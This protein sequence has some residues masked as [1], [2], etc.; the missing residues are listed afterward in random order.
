MS[1]YCSNCPVLHF[2]N[3]TLAQ[4]PEHFNCHNLCRYDVIFIKKILSDYNNTL[5]EEEIL[6]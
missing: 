1:T 4:S 6:L 5:E 2:Y 3:I